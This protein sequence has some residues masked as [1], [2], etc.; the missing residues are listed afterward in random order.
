MA[1]LAKGANR[2][3]ANAAYAVKRPVLKASGFGLTRRLAEENAD[4]TPEWIEA[5][6]KLLG[7]L[8]TAIWRI[9]TLS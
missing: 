1:L 4:W 9:D 6:Q 7:K 5:R 3:I 2:G 8:A